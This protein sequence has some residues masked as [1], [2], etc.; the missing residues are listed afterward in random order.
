MVSRL[1]Y[2]DWG[3]DLFLPSSRDCL[4]F[5]SFHDEFYYFY[6]KMIQIFIHSTYELLPIST[7]IIAELA[8][9]RYL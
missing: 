1:R 5:I 7:F 9:A 6:R 3:F 8:A 2:V 4:L